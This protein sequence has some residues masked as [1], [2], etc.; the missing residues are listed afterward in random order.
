[1]LHTNRAVTPKDSGKNEPA[2][3][4]LQIKWAMKDVRCL[5]SRSSAMPVTRVTN[6]SCAEQIGV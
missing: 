3:I 4:N 2:V 6:D 1:M 5:S